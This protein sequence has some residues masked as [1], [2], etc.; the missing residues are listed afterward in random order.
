MCVHCG[1]SNG[2]RA[3]T[4][5]ECKN[6]LPGKAIK[7]PKRLSSTDVSDLR[8]N[9]QET[10]AGTKIFSTK[11]RRDGPDYW[12]LV[13]NTEDKWK[14]FYKECTVAQDARGRSGS[15]LELDGNGYCQHIATVQAELQWHTVDRVHWTR[16]S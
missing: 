15:T 11:V 14:C 5:K 16:M 10:P 1:C 9:S 4:C 3:F 12:T 2:N 13:V 6:P 7:C 8:T